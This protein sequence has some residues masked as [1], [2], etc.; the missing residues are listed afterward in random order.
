M[1]L[2]FSANQYLFLVFLA[3]GFLAT[4]LPGRISLAAELPPDTA[5]ALSEKSEPQR[6]ILVIGVDRLDMPTARLESAWLVMHYPKTFEFTLI[7]L[8][9]S[10]QA[11]PSAPL[12]QPNQP[13]NINTSDLNALKSLE[14]VT[15]QDIWVSDVL[16]LDKVGLLEILNLLGGINVG[17]IYLRPDQAIDTLSPPWLDPRRALLTQRL[18]LASICQHSTAFAGPARLERILA[19]M[20]DHLA[21]TLQ[22]FELSTYWTWQANHGFNLTCEFPGLTP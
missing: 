16:V 10:L 18:L 19:L 1:R 2:R 4:F 9:P 15:A 12:A 20:P 6:N 11:D 3:L 5:N 21:T 8:Y 13:I 17:N 22:P 7:P 14:I